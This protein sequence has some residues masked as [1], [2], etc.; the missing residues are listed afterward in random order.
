[1]HVLTEGA[2]FSLKNEDGSIRFLRKSF[3][4]FKKSSKVFV[5]SFVKLPPPIRTAICKQFVE[6]VFLRGFHV[7]TWIGRP[8]GNQTIFNFMAFA[9]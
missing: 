2:C 4:V 9:A 5:S 7:Y 8:R 6:T 3:T 1:M